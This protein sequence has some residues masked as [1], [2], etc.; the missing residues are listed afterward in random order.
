MQHKAIKALWTVIGLK[1]CRLCLVLKGMQGSSQGLGTC[2]RHVLRRVDAA[3]LKECLEQADGLLVCALGDP[4]PVVACA[5]VDNAEPFQMHA[6]MER[7]LVPKLMKMILSRVCLQPLHHRLN[8]HQL[9][10]DVLHCKVRDTQ[11][12]VVL[13]TKES[14]L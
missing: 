9:R 10:H 7:Q 8:A 5:F 14:V 1:R 11:A 13:L 12:F 6:M 4:F 3:A 2:P